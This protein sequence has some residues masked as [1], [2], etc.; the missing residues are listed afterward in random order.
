MQKEKPMRIM[1]LKLI[2]MVGVAMVGVTL[3]VAIAPTTIQAQSNAVAEA[4]SNKKA[5]QEDVDADQLLDD[6]SE[7]WDESKWGQN[8]RGNAYMRANDSS[9]WKTRMKSIQ[10]L[11]ANGKDSI[12]VIEKY[13]SDDDTPTRIMAAQAIGYL[14]THA[15]IEKLQ[16]AFKKES[17]AAARLYLVDAIGMSGQG[18]QVDWKKLADGEKNRDVMKH[19]RYAIERKGSAVD[20]PVVD[21]LTSWDYDSMTL[22]KEGQTAPDFTL[23]SVEGVE[24]KLSQF[25]GDKPVVLVFVY[26]DT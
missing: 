21:T 26:G 19:I 14:A 10:S 6:F 1:N 9:D 12:P 2:K 4:G 8:F 15:D 24:Y 7:G 3:A 25:K 11:V 22:V 17:D 20:Q 13:L 16:S 18:E 5:A 23:N